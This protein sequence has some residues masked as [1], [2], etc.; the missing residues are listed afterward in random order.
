[1]I[2]CFRE[3]VVEGDIVV[4]SKLK[5]P[6]YICH[7]GQLESITKEEYECCKE[8]VRQQR[9]KAIQEYRAA[10]TRRPYSE[11]RI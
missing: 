2:K 11:R 8:I 5:E 3:N 4:F 6:L 1:M 10:H 7:N 9:Y